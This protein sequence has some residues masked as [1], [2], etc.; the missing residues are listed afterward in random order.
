MYILA[1]LIILCITVSCSG[2]DYTAQYYSFPPGSE[3]HE[4]D[5]QYTMQ[6]TVTS[7]KRPITMKSKKNVNMKVYDQSKTLFLNEDSEFT[8]ASVRANIVWG[9]FEEI[10]IELLEVGNEF[11]KD[12][13]NKQLLKDG[14]NRL[15]ELSYQFDQKNMKFIKA[16]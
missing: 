4:N 15:L 5:W 1:V 16:N 12:S 14:P 8:C 9:K 11:A 6:I 2:S 10:K 7:D 3:P 13:Y